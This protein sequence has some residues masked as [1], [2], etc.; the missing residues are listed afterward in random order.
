MCLWR[1]DLG[2]ATACGGNKMGMREIL[3]RN[4]NLVSREV[5]LQTGRAQLGFLEVAPLLQKGTG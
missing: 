3:Q 2:G 5:S 1:K 4:G